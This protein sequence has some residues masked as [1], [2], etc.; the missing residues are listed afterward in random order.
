VCAGCRTL[1]LVGTWWLADGEAQRDLT[2]ATFEMP[3]VVERRG[4]RVGQFAKVIFR[5]EPRAH[6]GWG[7]PEGERMWVKVTERRGGGYV[8]TLASNPEVLTELSF[9]DLI[10]FAPRNVIAITLAAG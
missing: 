2:P 7:E 6:E 10:E 9:G 5:F 8:G 3:S 1:G 4:L